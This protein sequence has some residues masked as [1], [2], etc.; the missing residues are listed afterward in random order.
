M[1]E[2]KGYNIDD[3]YGMYFITCTI[4]GWVDLFTREECA[5]IITRSLG[6]C[7]REKGLIIYAYVI[8]SSHLHLIVQAKEG[9]D[10]LS[11]I[12]RDFKKYTSKALIDWILSDSKESRSDWLKVVFKY[13][14]D[15]N[16]NNKLYQVWQQD[17]QPKVLLHPKFIRQK[18][19]YIHMNPVKSG[20]VFEAQDYKYSSARQYITGQDSDILQVEIIDPGIEEGYV[21]H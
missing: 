16:S 2:R 18:L 20:A 17:N 3:Q 9:S 7:L 10:G 15:R 1:K 21:F 12:I 19:D 5:Q 6:Y 14:G 13:H 11:A 4:V 8:M